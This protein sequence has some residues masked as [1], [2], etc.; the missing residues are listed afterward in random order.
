MQSRSTSSR[1][2]VEKKKLEPTYRL[3]PKCKP[4]AEKNKQVVDDYLKNKLLDAEYQECNPT[5]LSR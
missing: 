2:D 4:S 3:E 5:E 1:G